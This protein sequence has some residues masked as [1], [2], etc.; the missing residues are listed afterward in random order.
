MPLPIPSILSHPSFPTVISLPPPA[1][2]GKAPVAK[3]RGGPFEIAWEVYGEGEVRVVVCI[4]FLTW[5]LH[6][7]IL[8]WV[9]INM[10]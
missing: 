5:G 6:I 8:G 4:V 2:K 10:G 1:R 7:C 3:T 9:L